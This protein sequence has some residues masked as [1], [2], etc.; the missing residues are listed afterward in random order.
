MQYIE[1]FSAVKSENFI[2]KIS[3]FLIFMLKTFLAGK[4]LTGTHNLCFG[5][6]IDIPLYTPV[7]LY[8]FGVQGVYISQIYFP[9][10]F[11][12]AG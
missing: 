1:S 3:I 11:L 2:G 8:K 7:L 9:D 4:V 5:S 6:K 12:N 10:V